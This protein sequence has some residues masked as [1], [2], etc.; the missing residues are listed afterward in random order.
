MNFT[1]QE[2][3]AIYEAL[4]ISIKFGVV[5]ET[6]LLQRGYEVAAERL[7]GLREKMPELQKR[8]FNHLAKTEEE[9]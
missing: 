7:M 6:N 8:I 2:L 3:Q 5:E 1:E 9:K 4:H